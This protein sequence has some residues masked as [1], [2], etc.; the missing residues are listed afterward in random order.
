MFPQ[1]PLRLAISVIANVQAGVEIGL[2]RVVSYFALLYE[3]W[4]YLLQFANYPDGIYRGHFVATSVRQLNA[5]GWQALKTNPQS[6]LELSIDKTLFPR[7][8]G[9]STADSQDGPVKPVALYPWPAQTGD[10]P[11]F[12]LTL[13]GGTALTGKRAN[14]GVGWEFTPASPGTLVGTWTIELA[15]SF[16][17]KDIDDLLLIVPFQGALNWDGLLAGASDA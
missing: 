15:N 14:I 5:A 17:V 6:K 2:W 10:S 16:D 12:S 7:N 1:I 9:E 4:F 8:L 13:P 3:L 11:Q